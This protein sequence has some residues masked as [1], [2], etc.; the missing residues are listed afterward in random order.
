MKFDTYQTTIFEN[1]DVWPKCMKCRKK[2]PPNRK[3][4]SSERMVKRTTCPHCNAAL[5]PLEMKHFEQANAN[6]MLIKS[7]LHTHRKDLYIRWINSPQFREEITD[8]AVVQIAICARLHKP[9]LTQFSTYVVSAMRNMLNSQYPIML[10][11]VLGGDKS[12][13]I[14]QSPSARMPDR[15][16]SADDIDERIDGESACKMQNIKK[17]AIRSVIVGTQNGPDSAS[18]GVDGQW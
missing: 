17:L 13:D 7:A 15:G 8:W 10:P 2:Y 12:D 14:F 4:K 11:N 5:N 1:A 9:E 3:L 6:K 16:E 18:Y